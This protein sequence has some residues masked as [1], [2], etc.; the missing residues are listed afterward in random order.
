M[1]DAKNALSGARI[2]ICFHHLTSDLEVKNI[3]YIMKKMPK[4][5]VPGPARQGSRPF[6][7]FWPR[8]E[9]LGAKNIYVS[10]GPIGKTAQ[11]FLGWKTPK[12]IKK[13]DQN[14][15]SG[16][17]WARISI[18]LGTFWPHIR[19][20]WVEKHLLFL[21][22]KSEHCKNIYRPKNTKNHQKLPKMR[23]LGPAGP[24]S[25]YFRVILTPDM[26]SLGQ[27]TYIHIKGQLEH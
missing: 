26:D 20:P 9:F 27:K 23:I 15:R 12:I 16:V 4:M 3:T 18:F 2:P 14:A 22:I 8:F 24:R 21:L 5:R 1:K 11:T 7:S 25:R 6:L 13:N 17:R 19:V 10:L